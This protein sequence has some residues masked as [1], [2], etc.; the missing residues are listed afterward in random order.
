MAVTSKGVAK[1]A[2]SLLRSKV[3]TPKTKM[4]PQ[5]HCDNE[6]KLEVSVSKTMSYHDG[7]KAKV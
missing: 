1:K 4:L 5:A 2:S 3:T 7:P 6:R